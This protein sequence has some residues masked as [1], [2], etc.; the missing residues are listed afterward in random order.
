MFDYLAGVEAP[1]EEEERGVFDLIVTNPDCSLDAT[2]TLERML[3]AQPGPHVLTVAAML[4]PRAL[5]PKQ[6][7]DLVVV[8]QRSKSWVEA[9]E[10]PVM[11]ALSRSPA[12]DLRPRAPRVR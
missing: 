2:A 12:A 9:I 3:A 7:V 10:T 5:T 6:Q 4:E 11:A 1:P 8:L